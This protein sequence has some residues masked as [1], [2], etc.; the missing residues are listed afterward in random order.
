MIRIINRELDIKLGKFT[1]DEHGEVPRKIK[2]RRT[3]GLEGIPLQ[4]GR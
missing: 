4:Y 2:N 1:Q 3:V